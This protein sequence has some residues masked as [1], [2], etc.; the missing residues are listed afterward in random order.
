MFAVVR[1]SEVGPRIG[2]ARETGV[3]ALRDP[4]PG[5]QARRRGSEY[6]AA[7]RRWK[8]I[9]AVRPAAVGRVARPE[10]S[11]R[12][13]RKAVTRRCDLRIWACMR[14]PVRTDS[15]LHF[16]ARKAPD[17]FAR[18]SRG[19]EEKLRR[20][21]Y[22]CDLEVVP[23]FVESIRSTVRGLAPCPCGWEIL[24]ASILG[25]RECALATAW[26]AKCTGSR[27]A[28][29]SSCS[30]GWT[31]AQVGPFR[32]IVRRL[33]FPKSAMSK[34]LTVRKILVVEDNDEVR[35]LI[36]HV[37]TSMQADVRAAKTGKQA[38]VEIAK[39]SSIDLLVTDF[40]LPDTTGEQLVDAAM[41]LL[42]SAR[43]LCITADRDA[44][45]TLHARGI[46]VLLKPFGLEDIERMVQHIPPAVQ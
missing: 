2:G 17:W 36:V 41:P 31:N 10:L 38:L 21:L 37:L 14:I 12:D 7:R 34:T 25:R 13:L 5:G 8:A 32:G 24:S 16:K 23:A 3:G 11:L 6:A 18:R 45:H 40:H 22:R 15:S 43:A 46:E 35:G 33:Q 27:F 42:P 4:S 26:E 19:V 28:R 29:G 44:A 30:V 20:V 39:D 9:R 1:P